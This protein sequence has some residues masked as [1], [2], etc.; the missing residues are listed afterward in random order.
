MNLRM[1]RFVSLILANQVHNITYSGTKCA[2]IN[3]RLQ[4]R[5]PIGESDRY[6]LVKYHYSTPLAIEVAIRGQVV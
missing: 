3:H 5:T 4:Q 2:N 1:N 6:I